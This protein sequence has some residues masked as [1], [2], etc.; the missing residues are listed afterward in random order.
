MP[1][2]TCYFCNKNHKSRDCPVEKKVSPILKKYIGDVMENYI[3]NNFFCSNCNK[4]TLVVIGDNSPSLDIICN[5]CNNMIEVKSKCLSVNKIPHDITLPHGNYYTYKDRIKSKLNLFIIIYGID[6]INK[7][8]I[9]REVLYA[10]HDIFQNIDII[11]VKKQENNNNSTIFVK[12]KNKLSKMKVCNN[13]N[14][15]NFKNVIENYI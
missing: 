14:I 13:N 15:I 8:I 3:A 2:I 11:E 5:N 10:P 4:K 7:D 1:P 6:R 12:N 9:I